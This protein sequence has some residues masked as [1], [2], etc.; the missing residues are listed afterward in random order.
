MQG[1]NYSSNGTTSHQENTITGI[2]W[3][4][5]FIVCAVRGVCVKYNFKIPSS[6]FKQA[7]I[8]YKLIKMITIQSY[9][10]DQ[11]ATTFT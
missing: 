3:V 10:H 9:Y 1:I 4:R 5:E 8:S 6:F 11:E 2:P 7:I